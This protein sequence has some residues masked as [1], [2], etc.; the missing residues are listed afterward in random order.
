MKFAICNEFCENWELARVFELAKSNGYQGVEV[1]PF[2]IR[3][4]SRDISSGERREIV[5]QA[6]D[7]GIEIVGLHWLLVSPAGLYINHHDQAIRQ[8][9]IDYL[10]ALV[11]LCAD[12]GGSKL[13]FGS[14]KQRSVLPELTPAQAWDFARDA[15]VSVLPDAADRGVDL[16][17][18]PLPRIDTDYITTAAAGMRLCQEIDHPRFRLHLD[19]RAMSDEGRPL[20]EI[21]RE[22]KGWVGHVHAND[23][24]MGYPGSGSADFG[25]VFRALADIDYDEWVS[26]E[27]FDFTPGAEQIASASMEYMR[28]QLGGTVDE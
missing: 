9:T 6:A 20:D 13:V 26:V 2:T 7:A 17:I 28:T 4:D 19:V 3:D 5:R 8:S 18:E 22:C 21:I 15:F 16:C 11:H 10:R 24:N 25:P 23:P 12:F 27:V 14:P 1:A